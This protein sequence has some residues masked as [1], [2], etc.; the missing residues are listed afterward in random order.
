MLVGLW[1]AGGRAPYQP[2][3]SLVPVQ[4]EVTD[5][6]LDV[7]GEY[8]VN[9]VRSQNARGDASTFRI[10]GA[11]NR[12]M[13][14][15]VT[16]TGSPLLADMYFGSSYGATESLEGVSMNALTTPTIVRTDL[17]DAERLA[18]FGGKVFVA[19]GQWDEIAPPRE[20]E[21]LTA[22][23]DDLELHVLEDTDHFFMGGPGLRELAATLGD[24]LA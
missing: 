23:C 3:Y 8:N 20:L 18:G 5:T 21:A 4:I 16:N 7:N 13:R 17:L 11:G 6:W 22:S 15:S 2:A 10:F 1:W 24:W 14:L 19:T 9:W 12:R